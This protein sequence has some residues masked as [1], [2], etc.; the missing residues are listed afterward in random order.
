M[1]PQVPCIYSA[2][3]IV[4]RLTCAFFTL[5]LLRFSSSVQASIGSPNNDSLALA[6]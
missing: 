4:L 5:E 1:F 3:T 6:R 2:L